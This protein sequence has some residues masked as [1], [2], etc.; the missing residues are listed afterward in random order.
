M[1]GG[2]NIRKPVPV[3]AGFEG[4]G[5]VVSAG[6][7]PDAKMLEG[8]RVSFFAGEDEQGTWSEFAVTRWNNCIMIDERLESSQAAA[9]CV[10]PFTA[11]ALFEIA[12]RK[13][14]AACIQNA[15]TGQIGQFLRI[16]ARDKGIRMINIVRKQEQVEM[17]R[18]AGEEF[19]MNCT[20]EGFPAALKECA[21]DLNAS[22][23]FDAVAGEMSGQMLNA[24]SAGGELIVYGGLSGRMISEADPMGVIF[25][26]KIMRGFNLTDWKKEKSKVQ[27]E[28]ISGQ[29]Q[30]MII[31]KFITTTIQG[32]FPFERIQEALG[33]YI[34]NMSAGKI[35]LTPQVKI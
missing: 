8:H 22:V 30:E 10:N 2:Y 24:L 25:N 26:N 17:L 13:D 27:F 21:Q 20:D 28:A 18:Q 9:L 31:R 19:V 14:A 11:Y 1:R 16:M 33:Q 12:L 15:S 23:A 34:R 7:A 5:M 4:T 6:S 32:S 3:I 35:L 29:V